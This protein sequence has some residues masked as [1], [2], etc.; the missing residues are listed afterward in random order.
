MA[1]AKISTTVTV[2]RIAVR[3]LVSNWAMA[4]P[5][6]MLPATIATVNSTLRTS[7]FQNS[8]SW[9]MSVY[10]CTPTMLNSPVNRVRW[11]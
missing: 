7:D 6:A 1:H 2:I 4:V 5:I 9:N 10:C 8:G 11:L 3:S